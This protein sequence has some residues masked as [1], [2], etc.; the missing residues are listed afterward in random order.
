MI[1]HRLQFDLPTEAVKGG[2]VICCG[3]TGSTGKA[4]PTLDCLVDLNDKSKM[5][6]LFSLKRLMEQILLFKVDGVCQK[7]KTYFQFFASC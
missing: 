6:V 4:T 1:P 3:V 2:G 7:T 5:E